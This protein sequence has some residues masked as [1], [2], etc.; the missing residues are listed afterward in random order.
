MSALSDIRDWVDRAERDLE[1]ALEEAQSNRAELGNLPGEI[2]SALAMV[3]S[4]SQDI[5]KMQRKQSEVQP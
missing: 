5:E 4:I 2:E 1:E 3:R